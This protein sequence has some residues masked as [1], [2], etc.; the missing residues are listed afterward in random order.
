MVINSDLIITK[1]FTVLFPINETLHNASNEGKKNNS[2]TNNKP[3][4]FP[5][6][7]CLMVAPCVYIIL[8]VPFSF[9]EVIEP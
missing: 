3:N 2:V 4:D 7:I 9:S 8:S 5:Q 1:L 6:S